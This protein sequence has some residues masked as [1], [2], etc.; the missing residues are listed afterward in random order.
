MHR[1]CKLGE[2][3][4][5]TFESKH[6]EHHLDTKLNQYNDGEE[7]DFVFQIFS[8]FFPIMML[9]IITI[10]WHMFTYL[11]G[12]KK[13]K[14]F[15]GVFFTSFAV[16]LLYCWTWSSL[17]TKYHRKEIS[18]K[19]Q[20]FYVAMPF[21]EPDTSSSLYKYL[22]KYHTL[23]HLNKG[24]SKGNYNVVCPFFDFIFNT[25]K[26]RVDNRLYFSKNKPKTKE[27]EWLLNHQVFDLR[28]HDDNSMEYKTPGSEEWSRF[29]LDV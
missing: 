29:P 23:H 9:L 28:I 17:H 21:F 22:F 27:Q 14:T 6:V 18:L 11:P 15:K 1:N 12:F 26:T 20:V 13:F 24:E 3:L 4:S 19:N 2:Y 8:S 25:Y 10:T 7:D 16:V 5:K